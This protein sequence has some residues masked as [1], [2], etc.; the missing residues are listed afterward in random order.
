MFFL[1]IAFKLN[2]GND[3]SVLTLTIEESFRDLK[4][5]KNGFGLRHSRSFILDRFNVILLLGVIATWALWILG[6]VA[7]H[8]QE[9]W[10][11]QTNSVR[12]R[13][14]LSNFT[15]GWQMVARYGP[16]CKSKLF[17]NSLAEIASCVARL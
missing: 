5:T 12:D 14:I 13:N 11:F 3:V 1:K 9:H 15:I 8:K 10:S 6:V 16:T 7:K 4:N 17:F 2:W